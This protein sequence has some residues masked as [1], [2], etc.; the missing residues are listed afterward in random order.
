MND[1]N[2]ITDAIGRIRLTLADLP[3]EK[4]DN[5]TETVVVNFSDHFA[6]QERQAQAHASGQLTT[7]EAQTIYIALGEVGSG[8]NGGWAEETDLATKIVVTQT[9][10]E[11]L[12]E[13]VARGR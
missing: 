1:N 5:L 13:V 9:I 11:L 8:N 6:Y 12:S 7:D 4:I 10:S 2:R 3:Q